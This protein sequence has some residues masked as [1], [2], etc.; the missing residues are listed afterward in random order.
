ML[1]MLQLAALLLVP[2]P[3]WSHLAIPTTSWLRT[4]STLQH[5]WL[6]AAHHHRQR[7]PQWTRT[8]TFDSRNN[9]SLTSSSR[10]CVGGSWKG[11]SRKSSL[12]ARRRLS[13][14]SIAR[15]TLV[16]PRVPC[17]TTFQSSCRRNAGTTWSICRRRFAACWRKTCKTTTC[18]GWN[19]CRK[20]P[21][22]TA[23]SLC[24]IFQRAVFTSLLEQAGTADA[25]MVSHLSVE[26]ASNTFYRPAMRLLWPILS[27]KQRLEV[28]QWFFRYSMQMDEKEN[29]GDD[30]ASDGLLHRAA[31]AA[32]DRDNV[33]FMPDRLS[34]DFQAGLLLLL[35]KQVFAEPTIQYR[36]VMPGRLIHARIETNPCIDLVVGYQYA[37][38]LPK[39]SAAVTSA[40]DAVLA[41]RAEFWAQLT[42][43]L[44]ALPA[45]NRVLFLGDLNTTFS[46]EGTMVGRGVLAR[47]GSH[48]PDTPLAQE[49][50]RTHA[51]LPDAFQRTAAELHGQ[52]PH[53]SAHELLTH[54]WQTATASLPRQLPVQE[55]QA[56]HRPVLKLWRLRQTLR[57][58]L[59][60]ART[61]ERA[62]FRAWQ[63]RAALQA[64]QR[65]LRRMCRARKKQ[66]FD[67][68]L[69]VA[70]DTLPGLQRVYQVLRVF[71]PKAPRRKLQLRAAN[72][73]PLCIAD[74]VTAIRDYY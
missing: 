43:L 4:M 33:D 24:S 45:R 12:P 14:G 71:A 1:W 62:L 51:E 5:P 66:R 22:R 13:T 28:Q 39:A 20:D 37:W 40:K 19:I 38:S 57:D 2:M 56:D 63:C 60:S 46:T 54:A 42:T 68:M 73:M 7:R 11:S 44:S 27:A 34:Y 70:A 47:Q 65:V 67:Q 72:G 16:T 53:L 55:P 15:A 50:C 23:W 35:D 30:G 32:A 69:S 31:A 9:P 48:A 59:P 29:T 52:S 6:D 26:L 61:S 8:T 10:A 41:K 64:H 18:T 3:T 49:L 74:T 25:A 36:E 21:C 17:F 58:L